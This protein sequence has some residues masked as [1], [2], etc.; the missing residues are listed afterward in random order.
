[1]IRLHVTAIAHPQCNALARAANK[2]II[3]ALKKRLNEAKCD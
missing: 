3:D 2:H 1:M